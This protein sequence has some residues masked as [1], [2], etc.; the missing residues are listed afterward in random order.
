MTRRT[1]ARRRLAGC[2]RRPPGAR[3]SR[4]GP[5]GGGSGRGCGLQAAAPAAAGA[6]RRAPLLPPARGSVG[7]LRPPPAP[8]RTRRTRA[9]LQQ[10]LPLLLAAQHGHHLW[11]LAG[12]G[13]GGAGLWA[14]GCARLGGG[15]TLGA[16]TARR[17]SQRRVQGARPRPQQSQPP[18]TLAPSISSWREMPLPT[19]PLAPA[20]QATTEVLL[21]RV[22][23]RRWYLAGAACRAASQRQQR[24]GQGQGRR[25]GVH[26]PP[27]TQSR[28]SSRLRAGALAAAA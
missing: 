9:L 16:C 21:S 7:A 1:P 17:S 5:G 28:P 11:R 4:P 10:A 2:A 22:R 19:M 18:A 24:Q 26:P 12:Q 27:T 25:P 3:C 23:A 13:R 20:R 8:R 6:L 15:R 14:A